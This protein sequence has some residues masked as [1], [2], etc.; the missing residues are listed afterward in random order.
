MRAENKV[1]VWKEKGAV[2]GQSS[3]DTCEL[4]AIRR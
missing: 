1:M 4:S 2:D 3:L